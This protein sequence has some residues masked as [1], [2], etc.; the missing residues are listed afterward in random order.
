MKKRRTIPLFLQSILFVLSSLS[1]FGQTETIA[2]FLP[3]IN[4]VTKLSDK[5]KFVSSIE[6]RQQFFDDMNSNSF[7]Y[8]YVLTDITGIASI[9]LKNQYKI[10]TGYTLRI[11]EDQL[12]HRFI[13]QVSLVQNLPNFR[14]AHRFGIDQTFSKDANFVFRSRYRAVI[15]KPLNGQKVDVHEFYLKLGNEYVWALTK[16]NFDIEIRLIPQLGYELNKN[17]KIEF[18][19]DYRLN[20]FLENQA[21][22]S[23]WLKFNWFVLL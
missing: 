9:T 13:Q 12:F 20:D 5:I 23:F 15:E 21:S 14:L 6:S 2:G 11:R 10:N 4:M 1:C 3:K 17:N 22:N 18:G 7:D 19:L 16:E 8:D